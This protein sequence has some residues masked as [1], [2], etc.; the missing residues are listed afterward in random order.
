MSTKSNAPAGGQGAL[1]TQLSRTYTS[2]CPTASYQ[3][4][5]L[6][7]FSQACL[8]HLLAAVAS[9]LSSIRSAATQRE[10]SSVKSAL[11]EWRFMNLSE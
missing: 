6:S 2:N 9:A 1:K 3:R 11:T 7:A 8:I 5:C 4:L 10:S